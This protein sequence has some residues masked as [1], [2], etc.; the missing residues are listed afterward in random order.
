MGIEEELRKLRGFAKAAL[1]DD[2]LKF[3]LDSDKLQEIA[4]EHGILEVYTPREPCGEDCD[5]ACVGINHPNAFTDGDVYCY[6]MIDSVK[7]A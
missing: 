5:C 2:A 3:G 1:S 6:K 7:S 4:V